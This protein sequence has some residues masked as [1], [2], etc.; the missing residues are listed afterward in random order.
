MNCETSLMNMFR[1]SISST[2]ISM[3]RVSPPNRWDD[4][5]KFLKKMRKDYKMTTLNIKV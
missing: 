2:A 3:N 5:L 1:D 4:V